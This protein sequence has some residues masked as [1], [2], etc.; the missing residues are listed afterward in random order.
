[1]AFFGVGGTIAELA[2]AEREMRPFLPW[3]VPAVAGRSLRCPCG[4]SA[5][6]ARRRDFLS[7]RGA[8]GS[9]RQPGRRRPAVRWWGFSARRR[10][11]GRPRLP[12]GGRARIRASECVRV[13]VCRGRTARVPGRG[14][15]STPAAHGGV[16]VKQQQQQLQPRDKH[17][18][19]SA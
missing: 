11:A 7:G 5:L 10:E 6:G 1:M 17:G 3:A 19:V 2:S 14:S 8:E 4:R 13:R 9:R 12:V 16:N 18:D 15:A